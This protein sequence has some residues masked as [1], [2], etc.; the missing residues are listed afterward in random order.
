MILKSKT[1]TISKEEFKKAFKIK[2]NSFYVHN[3]STDDNIHIEV[4]EDD[5][6]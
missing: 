6:I 3:L 2:N 5:T 1:Y 4:Y